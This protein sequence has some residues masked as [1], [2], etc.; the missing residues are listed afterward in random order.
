MLVFLFCF[1]LS[2]KKLLGLVDRIEKNQISLGTEK[3]V[4]LRQ[5]N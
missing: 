1:F 4:L 3:M 5:Q 2:K